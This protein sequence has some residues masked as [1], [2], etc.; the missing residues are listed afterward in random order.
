MAVVEP[1]VM[2]AAHKEAR[3][4][5]AGE[6]ISELGAHVHAGL[7]ELAQLVAAFDDGQGWAYPGFRSCAHWLSI[8]AGLDLRTGSDLLRVGHALDGLPRVRAAFEAGRLSLDKVRALV[9]VAR[10]DDEESWVELALRLAASQLT[11]VCRHYRLA[12]EADRPEQ[13]DRELARRG[14]WASTTEDGMLRIVAL[15]PPEDGALVLATLDAVTGN[16]PVPSDPTGAV[17]DPAQDPWA[18]NRA[19]A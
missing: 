2:P 11:R 19:E 1:E 5:A 18:A 12:M 13:R 6:R 15:L 8:H 17:P 7:A 4:L 3:D 9:Q 14:L 16:R 10:P